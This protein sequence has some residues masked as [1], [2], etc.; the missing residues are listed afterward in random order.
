MFVSSGLG[1]L[2]PRREF[3]ID[4]IL[5]SAL[6]EPKKKPPTIVVNIRA[7]EKILI[8]GPLSEICSG[9]SILLVFK[10]SLV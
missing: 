3:I 6:F 2:L 1:L 4:V 7:K 8:I 5:A 10:I 9:G